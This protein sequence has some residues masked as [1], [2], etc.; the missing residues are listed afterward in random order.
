MSAGVLPTR[1]M[2]AYGALL[3]IISSVMAPWYRP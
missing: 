2:M 3:L 1:Q